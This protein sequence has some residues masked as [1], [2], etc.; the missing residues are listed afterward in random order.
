I[1]RGRIAAIETGAAEAAPGVVLVMTHRNMPRLPD[2]P[3]IM[4]DPK[5]AAGSSLPVM[6]DDSIHWNGEPVALV[7]AES[8]EQADHAASL[9]QVSYDAQP[10][11]VAFNQVKSR[12]RYPESVVGEPPTLEIGAAE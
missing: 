7:L 2:P 8:Q 9:I 6:Q 12:A 3:L 5:G 11:D 10:A 1:A 4:A